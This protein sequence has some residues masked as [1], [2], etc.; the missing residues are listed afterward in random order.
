MI[1]GYMLEN[2]NK[3]LYIDN[4]PLIKL[5][6]DSAIDEDSIFVDKIDDNNRP[7]LRGLFKI[8]VSEDIVVIRSLADL[9]NNI[10]D[11]MS[12]LNFFNRSNITVISAKES[13]YTYQSFYQALV[14][15]TNIS[16][17]WQERKRM[18]G[19]EKATSENRMGRKKNT[20]K[21]KTAL[22]LYDSGFGTQ[23]IIDISGISK[24]TLYRELHY[25]LKKSV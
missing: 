11:L 25:R 2:T 22:K 6:K 16:Y 5:L 13:Y 20:E 24:S 14:D 1:Y 23:E 12:S 21:I 9:S 10:D 18:L 17:Y 4:E 3:Y 15:F 8:A 19:I 7:A